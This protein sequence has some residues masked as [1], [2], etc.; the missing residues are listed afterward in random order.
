MQTLVTNTVVNN[1]YTKLR[2]GK[3]ILL[4]DQ[5]L[6]EQG[7]V[8]NEVSEYLQHA[9]YGDL[10]AICD[11][12]KEHVIVDIELQMDHTHITVKDLEIKIKQ[13]IT[14]EI[15]HNAVANKLTESK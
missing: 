13:I 2:V 5:L 12:N 7:H 8:K 9:S 15:L 10:C 4:S 1:I 6:I 14:F 11:E 3:Y